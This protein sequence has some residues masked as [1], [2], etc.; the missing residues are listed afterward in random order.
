MVDSKNSALGIGVAGYTI[1]VGAARQVAAFKLHNLRG[2]ADEQTIE[3]HGDTPPQQIKKLDPDFLALFGKQTDVSLV[4]NWIG[5]NCIY[6]G[7]IGQYAQ[8]FISRSLL[9]AESPVI[10]S[11]IHS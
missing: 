8:G 11:E 6:G 9:V 4:S 5:E 3:Q 2:L 7:M 10:R 1:H